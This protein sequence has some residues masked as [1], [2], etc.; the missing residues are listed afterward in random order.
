MDR[1]ISIK[2]VSKFYGSV[3]ALDNV[4]MTIESGRVYGILGPNGSGKTTLLRLI[5]AIIKPERGEILVY[6]NSTASSESDVKR[7]IGFVPET[8]ALYE[9]LTPA[10]YFSFIA[11][12]R[13]VDPERVSRVSGSLLKALEIERLSDQYIG[14]LSFGNRQK[15][16]IISALLHD[17]EIIIMDE[18]M[19]GLDPRSSRILKSLLLNLAGMGKTVLISTHI[20]EVAQNLCEYIFILYRGKIVAEGTVEDLR[21]LSGSSGNLEDVFLSLTGSSNISE[22]VSSLKGSFVNG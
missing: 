7:R 10:E 11:A 15:V 13:G 21:A 18:G 12:V 20:L 9:S 8:P 5:D 22:I 16:A 2:S 4:S 3:R 17:P 6:G 19:N 1:T 14:S